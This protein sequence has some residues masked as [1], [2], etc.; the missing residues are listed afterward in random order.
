MQGDGGDPGRRGGW[1][2][3]LASWPLWGLPAAVGLGAGAALLAMPDIDL[4]A[5]RVFLAP[6]AGFVGLRLGWIEA[7]RR[8]FI[9]LYFGA[10]A[11]CLVGLALM[12]RGRPQWLRLGKVQ[13]L[14]LAACLA[15]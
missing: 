8:A 3:P 4:A 9:V 10:I 15:A 11:V 7:V 6:D 2:G 5:A 13:W 14:F 12:W 1:T